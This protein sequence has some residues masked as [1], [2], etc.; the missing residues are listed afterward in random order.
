MTVNETKLGAHVTTG[1]RDGW[2]TAAPHMR[3]IVTFLADAALE[4]DEGTFVVWRPGST[5]GV[6]KWGDLADEDIMPGFDQLSVSDMKAQADYWWPI[7][8]KAVESEEKRLA[9]VVEKEMGFR[10]VI[11]IDALQL[12]NEVG[13]N[14]VGQ[15]EKL[16][17]YE[18]ALMLLAENAG[19]RLV[20]GNC[21][22]NSPDWHSDL[23]Q[24]LFAPHV[25]AGWARGHIYGRHAYFD[26]EPYQ[27]NYERIF[28]EIAYLAATG[29]AI[30]PII[31]SEAGFINFPG[32][33]RFMQAMAAFDER[34]AA[35]P[36]ILF[37]A[38]FTYGN[39]RQATIA[40]I[41]TA[42]ARFGEYMAA[43]PFDPIVLRPV[44]PEPAPELTVDEVLWAESVK[45]QVE[46]GIWLNPDAGLVR[47]ALTEMN[48][49]T[50]KPLL[51]PVH[52]EIYPAV[53]GKVHVI[54][55]FE[56]MHG[57]EPRRVYE[58]VDGKARW[59]GDPALD[60]DDE[61]EPPL[62]WDLL[63]YRPCDTTWVTQPFGANPARYAQFGLPGHEGIDYG[64]ALGQPY[65]AAAAGRVVH[66]GD[67]KWSGDTAS[68]Y[69]WHVVID[70][71]DCCT[72]YG[73]AAPNLPVSVGQ[74]VEAGQVVGYSGNTGNSDGPHLH[75]GLLDVA[76]IIDPDNGYPEWKFGRPVDPWPFV[77]DLYAPSLPP[78]GEVVN[79][80]DWVRGEH[81]RQFDLDYGSGTQTTQIWHIDANNWLY[82]KGTNGEYER[83]GVRNF[84][85]EPWIFRFEDTSEGPDRWYAHWNDSVTAIG[86]PWL[87]VFCQVGQWY[88]SK[89]FVQHYLKS[90]CAKQE[91]GAV[92]DRVRLMS[93]PYARTYSG[94]QQLMVITA[95]W[96]GGEQY[97]FGGGN[98]GFRD[99]GRNFWFM[100]WLEGRQDKIAKKPGCLDV[101]W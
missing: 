14:D 24:G 52:R 42:S 87:P 57:I 43:R 66:A 33:D 15:I 41:Q 25:Q 61:P 1:P 95:E 58:W 17:A 84:N 16:I 20:I 46:R 12:T 72:V 31:I 71:G 83:L 59:F 101:G 7:A 73:H 39:W 81:R 75:F 63:D 13:G 38:A 37:A 26:L 45:E 97:D 74:W 6:Y 76:G 50:D 78:Q 92:I 47:A 79:V 53:L 32:N 56:D 60:S 29:P 34:I 18:Q 10:P 54:Q 96:D 27:D 99:A 40:N 19:R 3:G 30:G 80:L 67:R 51:V 68:A 69:G 94:G 36:E 88:E 64:V 9:D 49:P 91:G 65:Y 93:K 11:T 22:S 98:V 35:Y 28:W 82:I 48:W 21:A 77:K 44:G 8:L 70:H 4:T 62:P 55:G 100:G 2:A 90:N 23:W 5:H 86:A 85:G 89:K